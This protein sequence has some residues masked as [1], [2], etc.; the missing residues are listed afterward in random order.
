MC[1]NRLEFQPESK[2]V[3]I[4]LQFCG[5]DLAQKERLVCTGAHDDGLLGVPVDI[6]DTALVTGKLVQNLASVDVPNNDWSIGG[7]TRNLTTI[8]SPAWLDQ[9]LF[10]SMGCSFEN[11][12]AAVGGSKWLD[13]PNT[14]YGIT[15][16]EPS[17][18]PTYTHT[19]TCVI[20]RVC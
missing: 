18:M 3:Y 7:T 19:L 16:Y 12:E 11:L 8:S 15:L 6:I 13:V 10:K 9:V 5:F 14:N 20:H 2:Q 1:N 4:L 17:E